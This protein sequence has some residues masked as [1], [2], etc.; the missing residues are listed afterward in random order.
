MNGYIVAIV[1]LV[2]IVIFLFGSLVRY[3]TLFNALYEAIKSS[4]ADCK[5]YIEEKLDKKLE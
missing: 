3:I 4:P 2:I 1:I 5:K